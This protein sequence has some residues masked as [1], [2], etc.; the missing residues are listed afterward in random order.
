MNIKSPSYM[1]VGL[2]GEGE[3]Y[4]ELRIPTFWDAPGKQWIG[5][6]KTTKTKHL[7]MATGRD[8][9]ELQNNFNIELKKAFDDKRYA[10]EVFEMFKEIKEK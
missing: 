7:I 10:D 1:K 9:F 4:K 6:I 3:S 2:H 8:S 5:A